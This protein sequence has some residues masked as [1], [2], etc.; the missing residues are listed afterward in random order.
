MALPTEESAV[1]QPRQFHPESEDL[2]LA[3]VDQ[4]AAVEPRPSRSDPAPIVMEE[5]NAKRSGSGGHESES[6]AVVVLD[7]LAAKRPPLRVTCKLALARGSK[8]VSMRPLS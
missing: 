3:V 4:P 8:S 7:V 2:A 5:P 1:D 6:L